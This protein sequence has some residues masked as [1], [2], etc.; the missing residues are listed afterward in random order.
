[1]ELEG[2]LEPMEK[3]FNYFLVMAERLGILTS[4]DHS[5]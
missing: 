3:I 5:S 2:S 4:E 1:M